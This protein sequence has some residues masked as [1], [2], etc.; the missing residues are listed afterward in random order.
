MVEDIKR[1]AKEN[2]RELTILIGSILI[3]WILVGIFNLPP[4][5]PSEGWRQFDEGNSSFPRYWFNRSNPYLQD[6]LEIIDERFGMSL[7][8]RPEFQFSPDI[9]GG[10]TN[11]QFVVYS[12]FRPDTNYRAIAIIHHFYIIAQYQ[13]SVL[14]ETDE[15]WNISST[16]YKWESPNNTML[17]LQ[18]SG[19]YVPPVEVSKKLVHSQDESEIKTFLDLGE[20]WFKASA[21]KDIHGYNPLTIEY[22]NTLAHQSYQGIKV[23]Y[24][25]QFAI[26]RLK[27][28]IILDEV[29]WMIHRGGLRDWETIKT[30]QIYLGNGILDGN[31]G[32]DSEIYLTPYPL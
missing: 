2:K 14:L 24:N 3:L 22:S 15:G 13:Y 32:N 28:L 8:G 18:V 7:Y 20:I 10:V 11:S 29:K 31:H 21:D 9:Q 30:A 17:F 27:R 1:I 19:F 16:E 4:N 5:D 6:G 26:K 25:N 23:L 12:N